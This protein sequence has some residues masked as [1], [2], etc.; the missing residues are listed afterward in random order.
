MTAPPPRE[1]GVDA[2]AVDGAEVLH[3]VHTHCTT[4]HARDP[5]SQVFRTPPANLVLETLDDVLRYAPLVEQ[6]A[7]KTHVMPLGNL[8]GMSEE[9]RRLLGAWLA[10]HLP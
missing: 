3:I 5:A 7:V 6:N 4:C 2:P 1:A 9:E 10:P 8:S